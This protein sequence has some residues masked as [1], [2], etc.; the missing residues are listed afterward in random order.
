M[1]EKQIY[2]NVVRELNQRAYE[3][4]RNG[5][6]IEA[7]IKQAVTDWKGHLAGVGYKILSVDEI[8]KNGGLTFFED[9]GGKP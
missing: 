6:S 5:M 7:A 3:Y 8:E 9:H 4:V 1:S 2:S